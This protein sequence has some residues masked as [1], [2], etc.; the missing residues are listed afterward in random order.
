MLTNQEVSKTKAKDIF[1]QD[2][3]DKENKTEEKSVTI[4]EADADLTV[5]EEDME[6][7]DFSIDA[8]FS[9]DVVEAT[10]EEEIPKI[11]PVASPAKLEY[12][13]LKP[14]HDQ[15]SDVKEEKDSVPLQNVSNQNTKN[16]PLKQLKCPDCDLVCHTSITYM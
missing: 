12:E 9:E 1:K 14:S 11:D 2:D 4:A 15:L 13:D 3:V 5:E 16:S 8:A 10:I 7:L 6:L